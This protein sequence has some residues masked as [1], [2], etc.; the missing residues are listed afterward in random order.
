MAQKNVLKYVVLGLLS[1]RDLTGYDIKKLFEGELGDFWYSNHSQIYPE[2]K[3]MVE[4][5]LIS[6][7]DDTVGQKMTKTYYRLEPQGQA[8]LAGWME[9]PLNA[10]PPTR[11][12]F[13]MKMY[14]LKDD[15]DPRIKKL[16][17]EEIA[18]HEEKLEYL[19]SRWQTVFSSQA[20]K[21]QYY[22]HALIL[23]QAIH[24]EEQRLQWLREEQAKLPG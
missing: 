18:R 7:Y 9:E 3:K 2:L 11:D 5:G 20:E 10:L 1:H 21:K 13:S 17:A 22:G 24:R 23:Q 14:L 15:K 16:F 4:G 8:E 6:S 12:E 19:K